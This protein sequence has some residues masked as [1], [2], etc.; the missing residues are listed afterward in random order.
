MRTL[1]RRLGTRDAALIVMGGI[2][3][4]GIFVNPSRVAKLVH[5]GPLMLLAWSIGGLVALT[6]AGIFAELAARRPQNGGVYA[7]M[8]DA[9]HP[10]VAFCYGWTLLLVSQSGGAAASAVTFAFYL[11]AMTGLSMSTAAQ[12]AVAVTV[13]AFFTLINCLGVRQGTNAQNGF[14][15]AKIAAIA[16]VIGVGL[17]AIHATHGHRAAVA[18]STFNPIVAIGLALVP[19][20]FAYSGWQTSSFMAGEMRDPHQTL[21]R[22]MLFGVLGVVVLYLGMNVVAIAALGETHLAA[23]NTPAS[24]VVRVVLGPVGGRIMAAVVALSTL[25]FITNQILTSPRVY[26]QMADD[27]TFFK[28][29]AYLNARTH[30]PVVA[31]ALQGAF[32]IFLTV[33]GHYDTILN[34]VTSVDYI[35]FGL[36]AIALIVFRTRD[37]AAGAPPPFFRMPLHPWSTV[38]FLIVAWGVVAD[39]L[40]KDPRNTFLGIAVLLTGIP[41]YAIFARSRRSV[42]A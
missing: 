22:G 5:T 41:V 35:F 39:V 33:I 4:S 25:G 14:M 42:R 29:L 11:P 18:P 13:I 30:A 40:I 2:V 20:L 16:A 28:P 34:W 19:V 27:G 36:A 24:D 1:L 15:I 23:T 12:T 38:L 26:Y 9:F 32:A 17:F 3:G 7:Y 6:G 37:R 10:V 31:I 8:R 21:P